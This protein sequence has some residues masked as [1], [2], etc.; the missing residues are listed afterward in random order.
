M[1]IRNLFRPLLRRRFA[2]GGLITN[3]SAH[4][5]DVPL[6]LSGGRAWMRKPTGEW[7]EIND[8]PAKP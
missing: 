3:S 8:P 1:S 5:D 6:L 2:E 7:V 4:S